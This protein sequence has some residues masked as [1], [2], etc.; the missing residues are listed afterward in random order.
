MASGTNRAELY[1]DLGQ[2]AI[3]LTELSRMVV[4]RLE[5][6]EGSDAVAAR[7]LHAGRL[8]R[9]YVGTRVKWIDDPFVRIGMATYDKLVS[10]VFDYALDFVEATRNA[11]P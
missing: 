10:C 6:A 7:L 3:N 2:L 4:G 11:Q 1:P 8:I 9:R 5:L